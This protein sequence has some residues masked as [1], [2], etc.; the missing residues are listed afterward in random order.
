MRAGKK[1]DRQGG[2]RVGGR[3]RLGERAGLRAS[4]GRV[5]TPMV[6]LEDAR[7]VLLRRLEIRGR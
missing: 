3:A 1:N 2:G 5:T 4:A 7:D 6:L